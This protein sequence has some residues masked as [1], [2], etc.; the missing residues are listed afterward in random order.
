MLA[1][2]KSLIRSTPLERPAKIVWRLFGPRQTEPVSS[3]I[4]NQWY[5]QL[6]EK[7]IARVLRP[8]SNAIDV[9]AHAGEILRVIV[10]QA[11][12]GTHWAVEPLPS[13]AAQLRD[14]FEGVNVL[15]LALSDRTGDSTFQYVTND[16]AY[17]GLRRH[18][19][20][21]DDPQIEE[22]RVKV[23]TLDNILERAE[24][25]DFMKVDVEGGELPL[26]RGASKMILSNRPYIVFEHGKRAAAAYGA[27]SEDIF[28]FLSQHGLGVSRLDDW[29]DGKPALTRRQFSDGRDF[30][31]LAHP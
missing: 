7:I 3:H 9:G 24:K 26:F 30:M 4:K 19:Y 2:A 17:S 5:D 6:T 21:R 23:D 10:T 27:G 29:L 15:E 12:F 8:D 11:P 20:D 18:P 16:P 14:Q 28:D 1:W 22:I 13:F 31:F 25:I